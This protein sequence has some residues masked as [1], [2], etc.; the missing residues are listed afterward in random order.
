MSQFD[1]TLLT[2]VQKNFFQ[3]VWPSLTFKVTF[4]KHLRFGQNFPPFPTLLEK[5]SLT[6]VIM[7]FLIFCYSAISI[8]YGW[9]WRLSI[10]SLC[11]KEKKEATVTFFVGVLFF[12][13]ILIYFFS[14]GML[15]LNNFTQLWTSSLDGPGFLRTCYL[16]AWW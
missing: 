5:I 16:V 9:F 11:E 10:S 3:I 12:M 6:K 14:T 13:T 2:S 15:L 8:V 4:V 7:I 1:L